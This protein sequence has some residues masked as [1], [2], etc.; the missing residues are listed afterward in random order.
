MKVCVFSGSISILINGSPT[1]E[2]NIQ[3]GLKQGDLLAPFLFLLVV[4]G[5]SGLMRNAVERNLFKGF[6]LVSGGVTLSHLQYAD[7]TIC[8]GEASVDIFGLS[9]HC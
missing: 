7:D 9:K 8:I 3:R 1:E 5:F 6:M 4:E 2:I